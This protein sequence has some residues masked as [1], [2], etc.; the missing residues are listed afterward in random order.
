MHIHTPTH[1]HIHILAYAQMYIHLPTQKKYKQFGLM[2]ISLYAEM[3]GTCT[4]HI[5]DDSLAGSTFN[6]RRGGHR[7][8]SQLGKNDYPEY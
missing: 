1:M 4:H 3:S 5:L 2:S 8:N 6:F 7:L